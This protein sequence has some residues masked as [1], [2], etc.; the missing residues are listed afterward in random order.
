M[1]STRFGATRCSLFM[2][3]VA[4]GAVS[5][6]C[7][8]SSGAGTSA[9]LAYSVGGTVSGL[10]AGTQLQLLDNG[11]D[12]LML[13]AS[14]AFTFATPLAA[15]SR[16]QVAVQQ[17]PRGLS[18]AVSNGSGIMGAQPIASVRVACAPGAYTVGGAVSG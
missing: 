13:S 10:A 6:G 17:Q 8:G 12:A 5:S 16:Y 7:G 1:H 14:G 2:L 18:C 9:P 4:A 15:G 3:V 11:K